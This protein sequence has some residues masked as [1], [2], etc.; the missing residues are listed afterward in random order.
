MSTKSLEI[1][2]DE[3][4]KFPGIGRKTAQRLAFYVMDISKE[5]VEKF[6][7]ALRDVKENIKRCEICGNLSESDICDI[8]SDDYREK[9]IIC[10]V[11]DSKDILAMEKA[12]VF[13]GVYHVL[14]GK[15]SPLNGIGA[16]KLNLKKLIERVAKE[17]IKEII[18][19]LNPDLEGETT[20]LYISELLK[21]FDVKVT[22]IA[23]GIPMGGNLEFADIATISRS[24]EGR[25]KI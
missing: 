1:L 20:A 11:E 5:E 2:T 4:H 13:K 21:N 16:D 14:N 9:D 17:P 22:K 10:V 3:F 7:S 24:I 25:R 18:L 6:V 19:A 12:G 15:I 8:C 23:S